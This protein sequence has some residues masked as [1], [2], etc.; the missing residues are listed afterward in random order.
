M[1]RKPNEKAEQAEALYR[2]HKKLVEIAEILGVPPG[3]VRRWKSTYCWD[4]PGKKKQCERSD[5][6]SERSEKENERSE[7]STPRHRGAQPCN[8]NALKNGKYAAKYWEYIDDYEREMM[9]DMSTD[10]EMQ[11]I[12]SLHL[13]TIRERRSM[14]LLNRYKE[15]LAKSADGMVLREDVKTLIQE[16]RPNGATVNTAT[17]QQTRVDAVEQIQIIEGEL[18]RIQRVKIKIIEAL[19][20]ERRANRPDGLRG[21]ADGTGIGIDGVVE[22]VNIYLPDNGRD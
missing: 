14:A 4:N 10:I 3:T 20:K 11:L 7:I 19:A 6:K 5:R 22:T 17:A 9:C 21:D 18:T 2:E 13:T 1:A 15:L 8:T 16:T 12:E